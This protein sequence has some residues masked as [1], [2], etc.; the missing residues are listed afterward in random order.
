M[1]GKLLI[2][3]DIHGSAYWCE[4]L[5][6]AFKTEGASRLVLLG[7]LLYHGPRNELPA[8][9]DTKRVFAMLNAVKDKITAIRGNCDS[10]VDQ[11]VLE[12]PCLADY[13]LID[14]NGRTLFL[15]HG[16]LYDSEKP[17]LLKTGDILLNGHFHTPCRK[18]LANG[19]VYANCGSVSL[20]KDGTPHSYIIYENGALIWKDLET[21][22]IFDRITL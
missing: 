22:E 10:E 17:P 13:A 11:M 16:H 9:Y 6:N 7:D 2:A 4:K 18:P 3:S 12:F 19:G 8:D 20:P 14:D 5:L 1:N 21:G 15:T